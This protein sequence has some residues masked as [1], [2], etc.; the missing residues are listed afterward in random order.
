MLTQSRVFLIFQLMLGIH[1][2]AVF[3]LDSFKSL[4]AMVMSLFLWQV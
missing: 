3:I 1:F 2:L 4:Q